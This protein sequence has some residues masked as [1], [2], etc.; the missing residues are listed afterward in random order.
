MENEEFSFFLE[1]KEQIGLYIK[2]RVLLLKLQTAQ[3]TAR[4]TGLLLTGL[5]LAILGF[6]V[7]LFISIM[8][9]YLFANMTGSFFCGFGIVAAFYLLLFLY[10]LLFMKKKI[11]KWIGDLLINVFF[12]KEI[13]E[14]NEKS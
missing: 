5:I 7:L 6:F 11:E 1:S 4:I 2:D 10:F 13:E 14:I 8:G 3:K 9:G 12:E